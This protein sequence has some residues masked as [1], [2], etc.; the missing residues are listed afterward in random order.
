MMKKWFRRVHLYLGLSAGLVIMVS[1]FT[2]A[3]LVFEEE[4]Q[5]AFHKERYEVKAEGESQP[6]EQLIANL[7]KIEP[8]AT[9]SRIT[10]TIMWINRTR[11]KKSLREET[12][13]SEVKVHRA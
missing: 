8:K 4:L 5:H 1:C 13:I 11:K 12:D 3:L 2:G 6:I 10:G 7:K 9:V